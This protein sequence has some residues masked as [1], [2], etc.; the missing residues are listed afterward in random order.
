MMTTKDSG[1]AKGQVIG[2]DERQ[3]LTRHLHAD[4][5]AFAELVG[6]YRQRVF[7]YLIRCGLSRCECE[8]LFQEIFLS[9]HRAAAQYDPARSLP[10]WI[11]TIARNAVR[12]HYRREKIRALSQRE[13]CARTPGRPPAPDDQAA[14]RETAEWLD[15]ALQGLPFKQREVLALCSFTGLSQAEAANVLHLPLASVKVLLHRARLNLAAALAERKAEDCE[16]ASQ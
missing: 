12:S 6:L 8:D 14:A 7:T 4:P 1:H 2:L 9:I 15:E 5:G 11:F 10:A 13:Q 3:F 16:E